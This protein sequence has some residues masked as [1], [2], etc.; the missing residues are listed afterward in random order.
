[1]TGEILT[2]ASGT[3]PGAVSSEQI[4][5]DCL[6]QTERERTID[7]LEFLYNYVEAPGRAFINSML[8]ELRDGQEVSNG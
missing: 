7:G 1:M 3:D 4:L 5:G 6:S 8:E 2:T